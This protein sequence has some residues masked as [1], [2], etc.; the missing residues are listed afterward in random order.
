MRVLSLWLVLGSLPACAGAAP[1]C[2][3][4]GSQVV[5]DTRAGTLRLCA[6]GAS[7]GSWSVAIGRGGVGKRR[8][9]DGKTPLGRYTLGAPRPS[10]SGYHRF[11]PI[12]YPTAAQRRAGYTG[13]AVGLHGPT[14]GTA[15]L[16]RANSWANWTQGCVALPTDGAID[17]VASWLK[18][19]PGAK[20]E[21]R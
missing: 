11:I 20:V 9:G 13:S 7:E 1:R 15:W 5:V 14:R 8:A 18:G 12:Q 3:P 19:H 4:R 16:G 21:L 2:P 17:A 10:A 6:G